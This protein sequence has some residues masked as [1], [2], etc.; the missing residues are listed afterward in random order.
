[1]QPSPEI[2]ERVNELFRR[3]VALPAG[4]RARFLDAACAGDAAL[5]REVESLLEFDD[6]SGGFIETP[7]IAFAADALAAGFGGETEGRRVGPYKL[8]REIGRGGMGAVFEAE[9]D[10][11]EFSRRVAVKVIKRGFDTEDILRR[12]RHERQILA[13]LDHP[14]IARLLDGGTTDT[15]LPYFVME[16]I[17]GVSV[18]DYCDAL[19]LTTA[20]RLRLFRKVCAAV[21]YAHRHLVVHRDLKPSNILVTAEGEPKLLDFGIAKAL[22]PED[23]AAG[24]ET[25][26]GLRVMTPGYASPEQ[27]RGGRATTAT[28]VYSLGVVLYELLT[29]RRPYRAR[30]RRAEELARAVCE[31]EPERPSTAVTRAEVGDAEAGGGAPAPLTPER[32]SELRGTQPARLRRQ[33]SGDLDRIVLKAMRK[34]PERRYPSVEQFSGDIRR[35]LEGLPVSAGRDTFRYRAGKFVRRHKAGAAAAALVALA[36]IGG[37]AATLWQA[38]LARQERDRARTEAAKA[39]RVSVFLQEML[40]SADPLRKGRGVTVEEVLREA[41]RRAD[42]ELAGQPE[43]LAG[44][45]RSVGRAY[46]GL[47]LPEEAEPHL[48][49]ALE[50]HRRLYGERHPETARSMR[51]LALLMQIRGDYAAAE[52]L[53]RAALETHRRADAPNEPEVP[54]TLFWLGQNLLQKGD[55]KGAESAFRES[56]DESRRRLGGEHRLVAGSL[57][58][59]GTAREYEGDLS[60]A[61]ALYRE[62]LEVFRRLPGGGNSFEMASTFVSLGTN[63]TTQGRYVEAEAAFDDGLMQARD[64]LGESHPITASWT[65]HLGRMYM[66]RGDHE[67][68]EGEMRRALD[69]QRRALPAEHPELPQALSLLGLI[70]ARAGK[71]AEGEPYLRESLAIRRKVLPANHWLVA[72]LESALGECLAAQGRRAEAGPLLARGYE[73]LRASL[74]EQHPRTAE[75]RQRLEKLE[76]ARP[77]PA[78]PRGRA[79]ATRAG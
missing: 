31:E 22:G 54:D 72:N 5:R 79:A 70:L 13:T 35:H 65:V 53:L 75:A 73:G 58:G 21:S 34:E 62:A 77:R 8:I 40:G 3:A 45:R 33:L 57:A 32:V 46:A 23:A 14:H 9:R 37:V 63:L 48:R 66:L 44:V 20:E 50:T 78:K 60:G 6:D 41:A 7:A 47:A 24:E 68:A 64:L 27:V 1:L 11:A 76:E 4:E 25:A 15:G 49:A 61:E 36:I 2:W 39:E 43:V 30:G 71:P 67:R 29:G 74:G 16:L 52:Q 26:T 55:T 56:L 12:F 17:E 51:A 18:A 42:S 19:K 28:D 38:R 59:L 10:D 69:I